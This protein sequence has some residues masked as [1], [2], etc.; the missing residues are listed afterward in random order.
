MFSTCFRRKS[1]HQMH[2]QLEKYPAITVHS[3]R[4]F[5]SS[6]SL[7]EGAAPA[8]VAFFYLCL[9]AWLLPPL[10]TITIPFVGYAILSRRW[11]P[12]TSGAK[13]MAAQAKSKTF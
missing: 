1:P 6:T 13:L 2:S 3:R 9:V 10:L 4:V 12:N 5:S 8:E 11:L 7:E